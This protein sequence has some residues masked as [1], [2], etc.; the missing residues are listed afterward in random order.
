VEG[1]GEG[2][3]WTESLE[4]VVLVDSFRC[5]LDEPRCSEEGGGLDGLP[6]S[7]L[8]LELMESLL[9]CFTSSPHPCTPAHLET[10]LQL[11]FPLYTSWAQHKC[12]L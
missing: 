12:C 3:K 9:C 6:E 2:G 8:L 1:K 5:C 10:E 7:W 4:R 11:D